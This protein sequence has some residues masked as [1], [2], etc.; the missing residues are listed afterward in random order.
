MEELPKELTPII[1]LRLGDDYRYY[2]RVLSLVCKRFKRIV[3]DNRKSNLLLPKRDVALYFARHGYVDLL[4]ELGDFSLL[5]PLDDTILLTDLLCLSIQSN[6]KECF[7]FVD[8]KY[9]NDHYPENSYIYAFNNGADWV[10]L[11][12]N[13]E[14]PCSMKAV[15]YVLEKRNLECFEYIMRHCNVVKSFYISNVTASI[16]DTNYLRVAHECGCPL[17]S[18]TLNRAITDK[19]VNNVKY[20]IDNDCPQTS[21]SCAIAAYVD[22]IDILTL[23]HE[24]KCPWDIWT[25]YAAAKSGSMKCLAYA[26]EHGCCVST[27]VAN[28]AHAFG[29][30]QCRDYVMDQMRSLNNLG[31]MTCYKSM[32][33][34]LRDVRYHETDDG[35]GHREDIFFKI[36]NRA[37]LDEMLKPIAVSVRI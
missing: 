12:A 25:T 29:H 4:K 34:F 1:L 14:I 20:C 28:I 36:T 7:E 15:V 8:D 19:N 13:R 37:A 9:S 24:N 18:G 27:S 33:L 30:F 16:P 26:Y 17:V 11:L 3:D 10:R 23:L 22:R 32:P 21:E 31:K 35:G 2:E 6:V 5:D